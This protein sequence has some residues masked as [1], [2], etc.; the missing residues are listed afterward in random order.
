MAV[1]RK[2]LI[3]PGR[4]ACQHRL[5]A[6]GFKR[7]EADIFTLPLAPRLFGW[8]GLARAIYRGDG[9]MN[10]TPVAGPGGRPADLDGAW[11]AA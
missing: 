10:I 9:S 5:Q 6:M 1:A 2:E 11:R 4:H 7:H 8:V 3:E